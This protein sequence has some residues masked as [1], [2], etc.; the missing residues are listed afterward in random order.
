MMTL[1]ELQS[2][3]MRES[4]GLLGGG[5]NEPWFA[6]G[7]KEKRCKGEQCD[8]QKTGGFSLSGGA[9]NGDFTQKTSRRRRWWTSIPKNRP[10]QVGML[11]SCL[12]LRGGGEAV[13]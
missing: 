13:K 10:A 2:K 3:A 1:A 12:G 5:N 7:N 4:V 9:R 8:P 11:N 6:A